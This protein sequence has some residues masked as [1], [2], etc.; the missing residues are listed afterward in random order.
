MDCAAVQP[1]L[2]PFLDGE[3]DGA[4]REA[5][6]LHM[7][8][9]ADCRQRLNDLRSLGEIWSSTEPPEPSERDWQRIARTLNSIDAAVPARPY[10][11][12]AR[13]AAAIMLALCACTGVAIACLSDNQIWDAFSK[14]RDPVNLIDYLD[15]ENS[16]QGK[17]IDAEN[18]CDE[19]DLRALNT[20]ELPNGYKLKNCCVFCD[21]VVRYKFAR[22]DADAIVLLY[23]CGHTVVHGNK[24]LLTFRLKD[25]DVKIAQCKKRV[26]A[27]WQVNG[28][29]VSLIATGELLEF[30]DLLRYIDKRLSESL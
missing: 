11:R 18:L 22:G 26:S 6:S 27:S 10:R 14:A 9:C 23:P 4:D 25:G 28:T 5:V 3:L 8:D 13:I 30:M 2:S 15:G 17:T 7:D 21:G 29:A 1:L 16:R 20:H 24:P 19:V 12:R